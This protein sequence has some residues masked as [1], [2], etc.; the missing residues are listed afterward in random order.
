[1]S[2]RTKQFLA[3][4]IGVLVGVAMILL[5]IWQTNRYQASME[6]V[7]A[8]RLAEPPVVLADNVHPDGTIEDVYGRRVTLSGR[9]LPDVSVHVGTGQPMR[10]VHAFQLDDDRHVAVVLGEGTSPVSPTGISDAPTQLVGIF[11]ASDPA[12]TGTVPVEAPEGSMASLR[13]QNLVQSWPQPLVA[14][15][16]T[17][18]PEDSVQYG[19]APAQVVLPEQEG[20]GMHQG[21]AL[22]W[23]VFAGAAVAFSGIVARG[24]REDPTP[25]KPSQHTISA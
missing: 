16:V 14:G 8:Q 7:A 3:V 11:T 22:Q 19:L 17:L 9:F 18:L 24:F 13:L 12:V 10:Y 5:G 23:W 1:M 20:S 2:V 21:Y 25:S 4:S 6:D 15:Y